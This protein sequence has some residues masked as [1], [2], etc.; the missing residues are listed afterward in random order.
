MKGDT[1]EKMRGN[2]GKGKL[3][4]EQELYDEDKGNKEGMKNDEKE[5][6]EETRKKRD[7]KDEKKDAAG[8]GGKG[9]W[10]KGKREILGAILVTVKGKGE[11]VTR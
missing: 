4:Q 8:K 3:A 2:L 7:K 11:V 1:K 5:K 6:K 10:K 9:E